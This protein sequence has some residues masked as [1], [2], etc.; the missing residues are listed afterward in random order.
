MNEPSKG[1]TKR[2]YGLLTEQSTEASTQSASSGTP[3]GGVFSSAQSAGSSPSDPEDIGN[4]DDSL[5]DID[6]STQPPT[7][8]RLT[9][10]DDGDPMDFDDEEVQQQQSYTAIKGLLRTYPEI[11]TWGL[12][13]FK[14]STDGR[15]PERHSTVFIGKD[16][17]LRNQGN[18]R[19]STFDPDKI[20]WI[21]TEDYI[22]DRVG[23]VQ[24]MDLK[25]EREAPMNSM[26]NA[27]RKLMLNAEERKAQR[28]REREMMS[29]EDQD[30][31]YV[32]E[33]KRHPKGQLAGN[34]K[35][36]SRLDGSNFSGDI[37][38]DETT[39]RQDLLDFYGANK[40][41]LDRL[42][43]NPIDK[44]GDIMSNFKI[45]LSKD[46]STLKIVKLG[47]NRA[48][49]NPAA[50]RNV[51]W[52]YTSNYLKE[53][54][55]NMTSGVAPRA[56]AAQADHSIST[57]TS[58]QVDTK[59][60]AVAAMQTIYSKLPWIDMLEIKPIQNYRD[61][62]RKSESYMFGDNMEF[63]TVKGNKKVSGKAKSDLINSIN[64]MMTLNEIISQLE[65]YDQM[66][67]DIMND[68]DI[69][70]KA[71]A[72]EEYKNMNAKRKAIGDTLK[73]LNVNAMSGRADVSDEVRGF[74]N[75]K[76]NLRGRGLM[77]AGTRRVEQTAQQREAQV[78]Q[79]PEA[80]QLRAP[81]QPRRVK[82]LRDIEGSGS[83]SDLKYKRLGSKYIRVGDLK[84]N[85]LKVVYP[86]RTPLTP[87]R[88]INPKLAELINKLVFEN[89]ID[90]RLYGQLS[91]ADKKLFTELL[92]ATHLQH[93]FSNT[94]EDPLEALKSEFDKLRGQLM[95]GN[96]NPDLIRELKA[97][98][99]DLY[100]QKLISEQDFK[101]IILI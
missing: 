16:G 37:T 63:Y 74:V 68:T 7:R 87:L 60:E 52:V 2:L 61:G 85:K 79:I 30:A 59:E 8:P 69:N 99:V 80:W 19:R 58:S 90:Q 28:Q 62:P 44:K 77:G 100:S 29:Q 27:F 33:R 57:G 53:R 24:G 65:T 89:D 84:Q 21:K 13:P 5:S 12:H 14:K 73:A 76:L 4:E 6:D 54:L 46:R 50:E 39:A 41:D 51:S 78:S 18:G 10:I 96:N 31:P 55:T 45:I 98:A 95:L 88:E 22:M 92:K 34:Y 40:S 82:N 97:I 70:M 72:P 48:D 66:L 26:R 42:V 49:N 23:L 71:H 67:F 3:P 35:K 56:Y 32:N 17:E 47:S 83:A 81:A 86:N 91:V 64:W 94:P 11:A 38:E 36:Y 9:V 101:S 43:V 93:Q 25:R 75:S 20:D 15:P 1:L